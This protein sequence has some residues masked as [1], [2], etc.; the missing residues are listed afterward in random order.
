MKAKLVKAV[1]AAAMLMTAGCVSILTRPK[2][3]IE[4][5]MV[6]QCTRI[7]AGA[8]G[9]PF[10]SDVSAEMR[11]MFG[12]GY[13]IIAVD[14]V[15]EA[16]ID[17]VLLPYDLLY[18]IPKSR[19]A[20]VEREEYPDYEVIEEAEDEVFGKFGVPRRSKANK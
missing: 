9:V 2:E 5:E 14:V 19:P 1:V 15:C 12:L 8:F 3:S 18:A 7:A 13:P 10:Y 4:T 11:W 6:Y 16:A 17:T 20:Q